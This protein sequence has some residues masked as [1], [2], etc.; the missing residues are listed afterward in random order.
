MI[1]WRC[2]KCN[3]L[4]KTD[5][6]AAGKKVRCAGCGEIL[7]VPGAAAPQALSFA[8]PPAKPVARPAYTPPSAAPMRTG[9]RTGRDRYITSGSD[10]KDKLTK[11]IVFGAL[12]LLAN[13]WWYGFFDLLWKIGLPLAAVVVAVVLLRKKLAKRK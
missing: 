1:E 13:A 2:G 6:T 4:L 7:T 5:D 12:A 8:Q 11:V 10:A 9:R 3:K